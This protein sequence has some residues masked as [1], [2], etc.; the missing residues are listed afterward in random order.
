MKIVNV[1]VEIV[2]NI[3]LIIIVF[4]NIILMRLEGLFSEINIYV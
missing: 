4:D 1:L 3:K 2:D